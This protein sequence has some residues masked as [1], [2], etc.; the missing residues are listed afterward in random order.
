MKPS[1]PYTPPQRRQIRWPSFFCVFAKLN[2]NNYI[3]TIFTHTASYN[4]CVGTRD[5]Y[6][7][8]FC[9]CCCCCCCRAAALGTSLYIYFICTNLRHYLYIILLILTA[10]RRVENHN[11]RKSL[12]RRVST[13]VRS[14]TCLFIYYYYFVHHASI[15]PLSNIIALRSHVGELL[16]AKVYEHV[17]NYIWV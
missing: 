13:A 17:S 15:I 3:I 11:A 2:L 10:R 16:K 12:V 6:Y 1:K 7:C 4:T 14:D 5:Y 9:C 8:C